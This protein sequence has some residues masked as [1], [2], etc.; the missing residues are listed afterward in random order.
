SHAVLT[1]V[2]EQNTSRRDHGGCLVARSTKTARVHLVD[3]AGSERVKQTGATGATLNEASHIN[4][5]LAALGDVIKALAK[6]GKAQAGPNTFVPYRNSTLTYL[7]KESLGGNSVTVMI[8]TVSPSL[9]HFEETFSTLK[10]AERAKKMVNHVRMNS[11]TTEMGPNTHAEIQKLRSEVERLKNEKEEMMRALIDTPARNLTRDSSVG[12]QIASALSLAS[13]AAAPYAYPLNTAGGPGGPAVPEPPGPYATN[14]DTVAPPPPG[15]PAQEPRLPPAPAAPRDLP[16]NV[17]TLVNL[18]PD[19]MFTEK[20]RYPIHSGVATLGSS[21]SNDVVLSSSSVAPHHCVVSYESLTGL[22]VVSN[23]S[24]SETYVNGRR[25]GGEGDEIEDGMRGEGGEERR[26]A[27]SV[28]IQHGFRICFG[29]KGTHVFRLEFITNEADERRIKADYEFAMEEM[30]L[31]HNEEIRAG[32]SSSVAAAGRVPQRR[33]RAHHHSPSADDEL[34][35]EFEDMFN[36]MTPPPP[37]EASSATFDQNNQNLYTH[38]HNIQNEDVVI[39]SI[40]SKLDNFASQLDELSQDDEKLENSLKKLSR[41]PPSGARR[42]QHT[43][44]SSPFSVYGYNP[45]SIK[46]VQ[47]GQTAPRHT[48]S[49][50]NASHTESEIEFMEYEKALTDRLSPHSDSTVVLDAEGRE[51]AAGGNDKEE[52][53]ESFAIQSRAALESLRREIQAEQEA[54]ADEGGRGEE[55]EEEEDE[56][57]AVI[58]DVFNSAPEQTPAGAVVSKLNAVE[59]KRE[60]ARQRLRSRQ[61]RSSRGGTTTNKYTNANE[62]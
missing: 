14:Q 56:F 26:K 25:I 27:R 54:G 28:T 10:Y 33:P 41:A 53:S 58:N 51:I 59:K 44:H 46:A 32:E 24:G 40:A 6:A 12:I 55:E 60:A 29:E 49:K 13:S 47:G 34:P 4:K 23:F 31:V 38:P 9:E 20:I 30:R 2:F 36:S 37:S 35:E 57:D 11:S 48:P 1:V 39:N 50:I 5:S 52:L 61:N 42:H 8:A 15:P 22:L 18:N 16:S 19:P 62:D 45:A 17:P 21:Q 43:D 7:L 3:L